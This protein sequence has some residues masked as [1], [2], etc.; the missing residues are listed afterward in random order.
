[1]LLVSVACLALARSLARMLA[2]SRMLLVRVSTR[3]LEVDC[4]LLLRLLACIIF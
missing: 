3:A 1:M 4:I 2:L